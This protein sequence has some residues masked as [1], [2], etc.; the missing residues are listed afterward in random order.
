MVEP[1][2]KEG[3]AAYAFPEEERGGFEGGTDEGR[4]YTAVETE[5]AVVAEGLAEAVEGASIAEG[6]VVGLGL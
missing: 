6:E 2:C 4:R 1:G 3:F 5:E